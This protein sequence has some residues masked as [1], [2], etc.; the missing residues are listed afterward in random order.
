MV[1]YEEN[2]AGSSALF[3]SLIALLLNGC[4][5]RVMNSFRSFID[6]RRIYMLEALIL[7]LAKQFEKWFLKTISD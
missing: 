3:S 1:S 5:I 7:A 4:A 2:G 6:L